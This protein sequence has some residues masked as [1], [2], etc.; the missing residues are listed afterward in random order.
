M[1]TATH[2][3]DLSK[4]DQ[5]LLEDLID[6]SLD[7]PALAAKHGLTIPQTLDRAASPPIAA[8]L[9]AF[10][11]FRLL[12]EHAR[13]DKALSTLHRNLDAAP[14]PA[15]QIRAASTLL[16]YSTLCTR[17]PT[18]HRAPHRP[19]PPA[20]REVAL[21]PAASFTPPLDPLAALSSLVE[22]NALTGAIAPIA[23]PPPTG[24]TRPNTPAPSR[25]LASLAGAPPPR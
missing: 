12:R 5:A 7:L 3:P 4:P 1:S 6:G 2:L 20:A 18:R 10:N 21:Q 16:R 14:K 23:P 13:Q 22:I 15:E 11:R 17:E 19:D 8:Y 9:D 25:S 24:R